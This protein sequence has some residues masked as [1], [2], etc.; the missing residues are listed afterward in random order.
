MLQIRRLSLLI[1]VLAAL[2]ACGTSEQPDPAKLAGEGATAFDA[3]TSFHFKLVVTEGLSA[4]LGTIIL[5]NAEGDSL[6]PN[7]VSAKLKAQLVGAPL[8]VNING[9]II[10]GDAWTTPNPFNLSQFEKM[11]DTAG[12]ENFSPANGVSQ[13]LRGLRNPTFVETTEVEGVQVHH[14]SGVA[15]AAS[16][17]AL[18]GGVATAGELKLDL[19]LGVDDKLL[20]QLVAVGPLDPSEKPG[21]T[22]TLNL[23][24]FNDPVTIEPPQ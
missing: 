20:R 1:L 8:A 4:P 10:G 22:R 15:D 24:K 12:L 2:A 9:I 7:K 5:I 19:W 6:R 3:V 21:I 18:T 17:N 23:S 13:V 11:T 16:L 14:I